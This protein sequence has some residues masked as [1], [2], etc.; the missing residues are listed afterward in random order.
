VKVERLWRIT[1]APYADLTGEGA[2]L[3]GGRWNPV[4]TPVVYASTALSLA[5]LE[6]LVHTDPDLLPDDLVAIEIDAR[7]ASEEEHVEAELPRPRRGE[8]GQADTQDFGGHWVRE[9]RSALLVLPSVLLPEGAAPSERNIVINPAHSDAAG[10][11]VVGN[12]PFMFDARLLA[13]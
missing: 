9:S 1:R 8:I 10:L 13:Y 5:V 4:G 12:Y 7:S 11:A 2:R 6:A 3:F